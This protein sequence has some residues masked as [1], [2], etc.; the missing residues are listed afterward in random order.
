MFLPYS[1]RRRLTCS[2]DKPCVGELER[3]VYTSLG[4]IVCQSRFASSIPI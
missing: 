3:R 2:D 1:V 4:V